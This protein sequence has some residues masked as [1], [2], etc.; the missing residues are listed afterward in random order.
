M[1]PSLRQSLDYVADA[2]HANGILEWRVEAEVLLRHVLGKSRSDFLTQVYGPD[3]RLSASQSD[4]LDTLLRRRLA[5]EPLA[6]IVERRE[7]YGLDLEVNEHVLIPRPE[8]ELVVDVALERVERIRSEPTIV[9]IGTGSGAIILAIASHVER[10]DLW[11]TEVNSAALDVARK[12]AERLEHERTVTFVQGDLL[13]PISRRVDMIVSNPP[14]IPTAQIDSLQA[15]VRAEPVIALD[16]GPDGLGLFRRL[17]S[18]AKGKMAP[19]GALI[20]ELMPEQMDEASDLVRRAFPTASE[21]EV[22]NDL[23]GN[24]RVLVVDLI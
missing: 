7:F 3:Y 2:L 12:N 14:Y 1:T 20:V 6:Y 8:T 13:A 18:Q 5:G 9:D 15:E 4:R 22:R 19:G 23:M 10:A 21:I 11:A 24:S 17:L 16:G